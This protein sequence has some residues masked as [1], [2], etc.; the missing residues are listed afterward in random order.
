MWSSIMRAAFKEWMVVVDALGRGDQIII[1]RKGGI[2]EGK[3]GFTLEHEEF[4]LL[5]TRVHQQREAVVPGAQT[6]FDALEPQLPPPEQIALEFFAR[7]E[8]WEKLKSLEQA[9]ALEGEHVWKNE[10]IAERFSWGGE[11]SI[12]AVTLRVFRLAEKVVVGNRAEYGG[13]KSWVMLAEEVETASGKPVLSE[14][15][16]VEKLEGLRK[17]L[18]SGAA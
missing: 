11:E 18:R 5:P 3:G 6:R 10:V 14:R 4:L 16:F 1:L 9:L 17:K 15:I 12:Y 13:C 8:S 7:V 2:R